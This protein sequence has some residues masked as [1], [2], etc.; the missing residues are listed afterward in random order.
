MQ[1]STGQQ[2]VTDSAR[3]Y[4]DRGRQELRVREVDRAAARAGIAVA[5]HAVQVVDVL[6]GGRVTRR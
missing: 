1:T 2:G 6:P 5:L 3:G 4:L